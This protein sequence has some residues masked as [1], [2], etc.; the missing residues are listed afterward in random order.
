MCRLRV[1][2]AWLL[3]FG[4]LWGYAPVQAQSAPVTL[5]VPYYSWARDQGVARIPLSVSGPTGAVLDFEFD[6]IV[7][8]TKFMP[9]GT[10]SEGT[11]TYYGS[12]TIS[13]KRTGQNQFH[14]EGYSGQ[15]LN[16]QT[17]PLVYVIF[18]RATS[19]IG[20]TTSP[21]QVQ[22]LVFNEGN[23]ASRIANEGSITIQ[24]IEVGGQFYY[25]GT[26]RPIPNAQVRY[27]LG[28]GPSTLMTTR[29]DGQYE[30]SVNQK[31]Q[32]RVE[33]SKYPRTDL[34]NGLSPLDAAR[35]HQC[36]MG[37]RNDCDPVVADVSRNGEVTSHDA[38]LITRWLLT[39]QSQQGSYV[40]E[41]V[42][43]PP[44]LVANVQLDV[45]LSNV[46]CMLVGDVTKNWSSA[47]DVA[48]AISPV[49]VTLPGVITASAGVTTTVP[50]TI[51]GTSLEAIL[52]R[53]DTTEVRVVGFVLPDGWSVTPEEGSFLLLG[54]VPGDQIVLDLQLIAPNS[55]GVKFT[56]VWVNEDLPQ[57]LGQTVQLEVLYRTYLP[58]LER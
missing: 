1:V 40:G 53:F 34:R 52:L 44:W 21:L 11:V 28:E 48:R 2:L 35:A 5:T 37:Y 42:C 33:F 17:G 18:G 12:W 15:G 30:F 27:R 41:W 56:E 22:N 26:Q 46:T 29:V 9:V 57:E 50:I 10:S 51:T 55:G 20:G 38:A 24:P 39:H 4:L 49:I 23:V 36:S 16:G 31:G 47:P 7:D 58:A 19:T 8:T 32:Y 25:K 14:I 13:F 3:V 6:L 45:T 43:T 54:E